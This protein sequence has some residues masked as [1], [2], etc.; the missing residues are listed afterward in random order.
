MSEVKNYAWHYEQSRQ[1]WAKFFCHSKHN[2]SRDSYIQ[3]LDIYAPDELMGIDDEFRYA[4]ESYDETA[5]EIK[6]VWNSDLGHC[7]KIKWEHAGWWA[8]DVLHHYYCVMLPLRNI[9]LIEPAKLHSA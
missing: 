7:L 2:P 3:L 5:E 9:N 8:G 4:M 6:I 1:E